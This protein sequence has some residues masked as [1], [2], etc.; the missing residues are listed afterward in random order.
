M[1]KEKSLIGQMFR[2]MSLLTNIIEGLIQ[3]QNCKARPCW[4]LHRVRV[5]RLDVPDA[6]KTKKRLEIV[7]KLLSIS[8]LTTKK[9]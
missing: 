3:G 1:T 6:R 2:Q 5:G 7:G 9:S 8:G 4:D